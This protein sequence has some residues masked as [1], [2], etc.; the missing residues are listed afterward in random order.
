MEYL[1]LGIE[2]ARITANIGL[3]IYM[4]LMIKEYLTKKKNP[5]TFT[6]GLDDYYSTHKLTEV[7]SQ[8]ELS[9]DDVLRLE[10]IIKTHNTH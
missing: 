7:L 4:Y 6:I 10:H 1:K 8:R 5:L 9:D 2:I 3:F